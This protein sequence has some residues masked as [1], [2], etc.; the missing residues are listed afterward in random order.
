MMMSFLNEVVLERLATGFGFTE[1]PIWHAG[2]RHLT[3][4]DIPG[5][6]MY[7]W[8]EAE[9]VAL[10]RQPSHKANGNAYDRQGRILTCE[11]ASSRLS[12][13]HRDGSGYEVLAAHYQGQELNSPNDVVVKSDGSIYFTDPPY[14]RINPRVG[15]LR[16]QEL[17]VQGVYRLDPVSGSLTLLVADFARPNGLC[18]TGDERRLFINDSAHNHIRVFDVQADGT[19]AG[20]RVWA[21]LVGE[22]AGVADG[23]KIDAGGNLWCA[24]PGGIYVFDP[25]ARLLGR[26]PM[27]EQTANFCFGGD[28]GRSLFIT[29]SS[30]LYRLRLEMPS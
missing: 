2:E 6:A 1:G 25:A 27:P 18:F 17:D 19:L 14:G 29:A 30:S 22:G 23:M 20:G 9:G 11:H 4:S 28:D 16:P 24:G 8:S 12:R 10:F 26:M 21:R 13:S 3:F 5:D 7:R 15:L